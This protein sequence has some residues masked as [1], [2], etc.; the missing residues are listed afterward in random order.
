MQDLNDLF[1]F[2][3]VVEHGGFAAAGRA[4]GLPK[5]KLSRRIA[6]LEER[7]GVR[8]L[9]RSSRRFA[10][11][12]IGQ[13]YHRHCAA[14]VA[15]ASAA[16]DAIDRVQAEPQGT[17]RI[18]CPIPLVQSFVMPIVTRF[19]AEHPRVRLHLDATNRRVDVIEEGVDLAIRVR[20]PPL[21]DSDLTI[22]VLESHGTQL[23]ASPT[24][25]DRWGRPAVP[26]DLAR[27]ETIDMTQ[28]AATHVW[29]LTGPNG[30]ERQVRHVP[31]LSTDHM[32]TLTQAAIEGL[33]V[34]ILPR[35]MARAG[36]ESGAL[37]RVL[38]D[39]TLPAGIVHA[40]FPTRRGLVPAVRLFLDE[41]VK[42]FGGT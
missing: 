31:R 22:R 34:A 11:T 33:G 30:E 37:E 27:F 10:V 2:A 19:L 8:L 40:V 24:A 14:V 6:E 3:K 35:F 20:L 41:L 26:E 29:R 38:P 17:L 12:E 32:G 5:S 23:V 1:Y 18:S 36:L 9:Q 28:A 4:L 39:W 25:L 21:E 13:I 7:L 16:R 15:E 42:A